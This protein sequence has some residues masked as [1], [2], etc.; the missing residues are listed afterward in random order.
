MMEACSWLALASSSELRAQAQHLQAQTAA[1]QAAALHLPQS[2]SVFVG[3]RG[4]GTVVP[5]HWPLAD[6]PMG[7]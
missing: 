7:Q 4:A 6:M 5:G 2:R 3:R 1:L